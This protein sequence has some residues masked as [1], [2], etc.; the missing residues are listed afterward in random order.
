MEQWSAPNLLCFS[1]SGSPPV[2]TLDGLVR[3][4]FDA[5]KQEAD[6]LQ[7]SAPGTK[8]ALRGMS[9]KSSLAVAR[10]LSTL[11]WVRLGSCVHITLTYW[12]NWPKTKIEI[13]A[14]KQALAMWFG[15]NADC[16]IWRLEFHRESKKRGDPGERVPHW[17]VLA[18]VG[19]RCLES[20]QRLVRSWWSKG[21]DGNEHNEAVKFSDGNG[22]ASYYLA[23]H[24]GKRDQAP[25]FEV[26]RWWGY[27]NRAV[28]LAGQ[29]ISALGE[30]LVRD[31][32]WWARLYR[33][34]TGCKNRNARGFS[35]F[36]SERGQTQARQ[37]V[38][39]WCGFEQATRAYGGRP[40]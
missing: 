39:E 19:K 9:V 27:I 30:V 20:F 33:R 7:E 26:G 14:I 23:M 15:R 29:R 24:A 6:P 28:L 11:D 8:R 16:G 13:Q 25:P 2:P 5:E 35:W 10:V 40:F 31:F 12:H 18:F 3:D 32:V 22:R 36:L 1:R 17:H 34:S 37:W 38:A 21:A 4:E